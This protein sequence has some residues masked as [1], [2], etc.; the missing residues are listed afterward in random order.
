MKSSFF[1]ALT[2]L[3]WCGVNTAP[4]ACAS[5]PG[6]T[7]VWL[8]R[9]VPRVLCLVVATS[10]GDALEDLGRQAHGGEAVR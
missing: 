1:E 7:V 10:P 4:L 5:R 9:L 8:P 3:V 2:G 6:K